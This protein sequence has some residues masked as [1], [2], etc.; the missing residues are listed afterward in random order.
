[1]THRYHIKDLHIAIIAI[2]VAMG[3]AI[4]MQ[5]MVQSFSKTLNNHLEKQ[6]SADIY[7]KIA[8]PDHSP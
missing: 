6:L 7:L 2:L 5:I 1:M 8:T 3:S 4:G